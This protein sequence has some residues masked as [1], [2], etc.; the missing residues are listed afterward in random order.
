VEADPNSTYKTWFYFSVKG[1]PLGATLT[2]CIINL[3][4]QV[5]LFKEGHLPVFRS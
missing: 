3:S 4:N 5:K 2:F 1:V